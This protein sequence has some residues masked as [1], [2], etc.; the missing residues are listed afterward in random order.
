MQKCKYK[1]TKD[2]LRDNARFMDDLVARSRDH[3]ETF[4]PD[5]MPEWIRTYR[6]QSPADEVDLKAQTTAG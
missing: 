4:R 2:Y 6:P 1:S 3:I 5:L